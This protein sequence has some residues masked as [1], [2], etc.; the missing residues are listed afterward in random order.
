M[1]MLKA[2]VEYWYVIGTRNV[3]LTVEQCR[4]CEEFVCALCRRVV[5]GVRVL[6]CLLCLNLYSDFAQLCIGLRVGC[7]LLCEHHH[8]IHKILGHT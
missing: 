7:V 8:F 3:L 1:H 6:F 4:R 5:D 2:Q